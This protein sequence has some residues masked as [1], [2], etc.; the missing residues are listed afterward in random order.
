VSPFDGILELHGRTTPIAPAHDGPGAVAEGVQR[1]HRDEGAL[2]DPEGAKRRDR[3]QNSARSSALVAVTVP[4]ARGRMLS[5]VA[6]FGKNPWKHGTRTVA[7]I[8]RVSVTATEYG[9]DDSFDAFTTFVTF[10]VPD[11]SGGSVIV[12]RKIRM[13]SPPTPGSSIDVAYLPDKVEDLVFDLDTLRPPEA[14]TGR[15]WG[16]GVFEV[17]D[18]GGHHSGE[19]SPDLERE[20]ELFRSG[21][22]IQATVVSCQRTNDKQRRAS[23]CYA[24]ILRVSEEVVLNKDLW[25]PP[26]AIPEPGALIQTVA[27]AD[28]ALVALDTDERYDGPPGRMLV[29]TTPAPT[30]YETT[31]QDLAQSNQ[32]RAALATGTQ[33]SA[34]NAA[35]QEQIDNIEAMRASG[36][37]DEATFTMVKANLIATMD[38]NAQAA[39]QVNRAFD[40][41][42]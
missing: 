23:Q 10:R 33:L 32:A 24:L 31:G 1:S 18:L 35:L 11:G 42:G 19:P 17:D 38:R 4:V 36:A 20:R 13:V 29:F 9:L 41:T 8:E 12:E 14:A 15:G 27:S 39:E 40:P 37:M 6:L 28:G 21:T 2:A 25:A 22:P 26:G 16:A 34:G 5:E 30:P 3:G 7:T